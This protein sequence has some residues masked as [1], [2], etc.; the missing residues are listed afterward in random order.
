MIKTVLA[1][2]APW[3]VWEEEEKPKHVPGKKAAPI[4]FDRATL[5]YFA[6]AREQINNYKRERPRDKSTGRFKPVN[7]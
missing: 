4:K 5:D 3:P 2:N 1:P 6:E 7:V